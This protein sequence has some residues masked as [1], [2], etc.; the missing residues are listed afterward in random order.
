MNGMKLSGIVTKSSVMLH[1]M[2]TAWR[3]TA[4]LFRV[5]QP[6]DKKI[7]MLLKW[8]PESFGT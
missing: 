4:T 1:Y 3:M 8:R 6:S 2:R 5:F 7:L